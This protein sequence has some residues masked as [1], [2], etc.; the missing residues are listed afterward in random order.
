MYDI[1]AVDKLIDQHTANPANEYQNEVRALYRDA[2]KRTAR[3]V[4]HASETLEQPRERFAGQDPIMAEVI[5]AIH[6]HLLLMPIPQFTEL[7]QLTTF[8]LDEHVKSMID[9]YKTVTGMLGRGL[10]QDQIEAGVA[11]GGFN[12][13]AMDFESKVSAPFGVL[14]R[15]VYESEDY[16]RQGVSTFAEVK[17]SEEERKE[18]PTTEQGYIDALFYRFSLL[19]DHLLFS[20]HTTPIDKKNLLVEVCCVSLQFFYVSLRQLQHMSESFCHKFYSMDSLLKEKLQCVIEKETMEYDLVIMDLV[21]ETLA[22]ASLRVQYFAK[23]GLF[24]FDV[25][26]KFFAQYMIANGHGLNNSEFYTAL[27]KRNLLPRDIVVSEATKMAKSSGLW[28]RDE[29][30][31]AFLIQNLSELFYPCSPENVSIEARCQFCD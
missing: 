6:R 30:L 8:D 16:F 5:E 26:L 25:Y 31:V 11:T 27:S 19:V 18:Q 7:F 15:E 10:S 13:R 23:K 28:H 22:K 2:L 29:K 4:N 21:A 14:S 12:Q 20:N 24:G 9:E 1:K 17:F 3:M